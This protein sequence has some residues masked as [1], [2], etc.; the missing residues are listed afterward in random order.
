MTD[1][2]LRSAEDRARRRQFAILCTHT[3]LFQATTFL[4]RPTASYRAIEL[5]VSSAW[6]GLLAASFALVPL[7]VALPAGDLADRYGESRIMLAGALVIGV[8]GVM[9]VVD[10]DSFAMLLAGTI[11]LG[12]GHLLCAVGQHAMVAN[13]MP[14]GRFDSAF[15]YYTFAGSIGQAAGPGLLVFFGSKGSLPRTEDAFLAAAGVALIL[16]VVTAFARRTPRTQRST[17][18]GERKV[19]TLL[20]TPGLGRALVVSGVVLAAMDITLVYLPAL[21]AE[22]GLPVAVVSALLT[23]RA[24]AAMVS[25]LFTGVLTAWLGRRV[26]LVASIGASAVATAVVP[27]PVPLW[28]VFAAVL[29]LGFGL[30]VCQP[31][32]L[33]WLAEIAAPGLRGRVMSLRLVGNRF[34]QVVV[35][36]GIGLVAAGLG[37]AGVLWV[38]A[39]TLLGAAA[40]SRSVPMDTPEEP[41]NQPDP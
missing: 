29:V 3:L 18:P 31:A 1:R 26:L 24:V 13:L 35:P 41:G 19:G 28:L 34:G 30:G 6:L 23:A 20:R 17:E 5:G 14:P 10:A 12:T 15:G 22:E 25:R 32:T 2:G 21:G 4:L 7:L 37:A 27:L 9:F 39:G 40:A 33:A 16:V 36:S 11:V 8:G 38:T